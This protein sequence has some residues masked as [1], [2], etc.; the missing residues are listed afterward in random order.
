MDMRSLVVIAALAGTAAAGPVVRIGSV[1]GT[2]TS[3]PGGRDDGITA[4]AGFRSGIFTAEIDYTYL[5]YDGT[6]GIGGDSHRVGGLLQAAVL[7]QHCRGGESYCPHVDIEAGMGRRWIEWQIER[8]GFEF[9]NLPGSTIDRTGTD[10][11]IGLSVNMGLR[12][13]VHYFVFKP[14]SGM[15]DISCRTTTGG[16]PMQV[17]GNE[18]GVMFEA[19]IAIGG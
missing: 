13:G 6:T 15:P 10:Y 8:S 7:Q 11:R 1:G 4:G 9:N 18:H 14:D 16:C 5:S 3:A 2:D 19:A 12:F 17:D